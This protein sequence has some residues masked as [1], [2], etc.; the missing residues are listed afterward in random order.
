MHVDV[1]VGVKLLTCRGTKMRTATTSPSACG[2]I[3]L[4]LN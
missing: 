1:A 4:V 3:L 2:L